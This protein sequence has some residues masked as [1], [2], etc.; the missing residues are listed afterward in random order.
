MNDFLEFIEN[1]FV[2]VKGTLLFALAAI[3]VVFLVEIVLLLGISGY[4]LLECT[5]DNVAVFSPEALHFL[6]V[7]WKYCLVALVLTP[8]AVIV[9]ATILLMFE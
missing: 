3:L 8:I 9:F 7:Y 6:F 2:Y 4:H 5:R 1:L